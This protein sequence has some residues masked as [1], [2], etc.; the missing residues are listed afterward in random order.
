MIE[1]LRMLGIKNFMPGTGIM[2]RML[3]NEITT[4]NLSAN[5][6]EMV[7]AAWDTRHYVPFDQIENVD[8]VNPNITKEEVEMGIYSE[9][10]YKRNYVE[11]IERYLKVI[12]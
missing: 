5:E 12:M 11:Q 1:I 6:V 9:E 4:K 7:L 10:E 2:E 8:R 3:R